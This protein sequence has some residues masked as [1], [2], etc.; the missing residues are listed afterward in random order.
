MP[1]GERA[2]WASSVSDA[3]LD[4]LKTA[5]AVWYGAS[6]LNREAFRTQ[7][8]DPTTSDETV[9]RLRSAARGMVEARTHDDLTRAGDDLAAA[10]RQI[11]PDRW[12]GFLADAQR[13]A[14]AAV[15]QGRMSGIIQAS[16]DG[17]DIALPL[18]LLGGIAVLHFLP[19]HDTKTPRTSP[20][21]NKPTTFQNAPPDEEKPVEAPAPDAAKPGKVMPVPP[22]REGETAADILRPGG[23]LVGEEGSSSDIRLLPG[24]QEDASKLFHRLTKGGTVINVKGLPGVRIALPNRDAFNYRAKSKSGPPTIDVEVRGLSIRKLKFPGG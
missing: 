17:A 11:G 4:R 3:A 14:F 23:Q 9:D 1:R 6:R 19:P 15:K 12:P 13:R 21:P 2:R 10:A 24:D 18:L 20:A 22:P 7:L 16:A 5:V 8:L